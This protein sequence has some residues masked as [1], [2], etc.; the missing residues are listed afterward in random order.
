MEKECYGQN[1]LSGRYITKIPE[2]EGREWIEK[3]R[4]KQK[5]K[6]AC[7]Q[8]EDNKAKQQVDVV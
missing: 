6:G 2:E 8:A 7:V 4:D 1:S 3:A 5:Q